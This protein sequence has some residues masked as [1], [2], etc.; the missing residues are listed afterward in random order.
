[1]CFSLHFLVE[2]HKGYREG[3]GDQ[4]SSAFSRVPELVFFFF[5]R[6]LELVLGMEAIG[7]YGSTRSKQRHRNSLPI[8]C[9]WLQT[10]RKFIEA[11]RR[12]ILRR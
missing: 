4:E 5:D 7:N 3:A 6:I 2:L 11:S 10:C 12:T 9:V 8:G 1:M